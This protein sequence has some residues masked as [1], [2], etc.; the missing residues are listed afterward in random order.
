MIVIIEVEGVVTISD[1]KTENSKRM[2]DH[3]IS[4]EDVT[5]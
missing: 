2:N 4:E 3:R 1:L 5:S